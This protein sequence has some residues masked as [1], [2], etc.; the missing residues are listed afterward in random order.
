MQGSEDSHWSMWMWPHE[1]LSCL[2]ALL[3]S[4]GLWGQGAF[5]GVVVTWIICEFIKSKILWRESPMC[6]VSSCSSVKTNVVTGE[7]CPCSSFSCP[8]GI[9]LL[10]CPVSGLVGV[11]SSLVLGLAVPGGQVDASMSPADLMFR[12]TETVSWTISRRITDPPI[13][14][15]THLQSTS[16]LHMEAGA[17]S[18]A[19]VIC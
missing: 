13:F 1:P 9:N 18:K 4:S 12:S 8:E 16:W 2:L 11:A 10:C 19:S 15:L 14:L 5:H 7:N 6:S 3:L 17:G